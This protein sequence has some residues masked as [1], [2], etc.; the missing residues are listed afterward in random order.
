MIGMAVRDQCT[1]DR[2]MRVDM[3]AARLTQQSE[4]GW[5]EPTLEA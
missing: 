3:E 2:P 1:R 5:I 4:L